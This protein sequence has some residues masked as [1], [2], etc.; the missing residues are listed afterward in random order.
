[1]KR[2][3]MSLSLWTIHSFFS[4]IKLEIEKDGKEIY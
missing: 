3:G 2:I 1:M 4:I